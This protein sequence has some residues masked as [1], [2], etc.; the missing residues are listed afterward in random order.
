M[1]AEISGTWL[2]EP[3]DL[4]VPYFQT[5]IFR[6]ENGVF[7]LGELGSLVPGNKNHG[8]FTTSGLMREKWR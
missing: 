7:L 1:A 8:D 2:Y 6:H 3:W 5:A 4:G